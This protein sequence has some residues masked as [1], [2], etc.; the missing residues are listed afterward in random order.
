MNDVKNEMLKDLTLLWSSDLDDFFALI[1][2]NVLDNAGLD[3]FNIIISSDHEDEAK[4][5]AKYYARLLNSKEYRITSSKYVQTV[6]MD[7]LLEIDKFDDLHGVIFVEDFNEFENTN[8]SYA[9]VLMNLKQMSKDSINDLVFVLYNKV[10]TFELNS[11]LDEFGI[12]D[13]F[14]FNFN[15]LNHTKK[16]SE[17]LISYIF[18]QKNVKVDDSVLHELAETVLN[19]KSLNEAIQCIET[20]FTVLNDI[21][22]ELCSTD[23]ENFKK[24]QEKEEEL[25]E[26][27]K[28][29]RRNRKERNVLLLPLSTL[30]SVNVSKYESMV[31]G[32]KDQGYYVSQ[33]EPVPKMLAGM[34][35]AQGDQLDSI[36]VLNTSQTENECIKEELLKK[37]IPFTNTHKDVDEKGEKY[38]QCH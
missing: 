14:N 27:K 20:K 7:D 22:E 38:T 16:S 19:T 9:S 36:Y 3:A 26:A 37:L 33:L 23:E 31:E 17:R 15:L 6:L 11:R 8:E 29:A 24:I 13:T 32:V 1:D 5:F 4:R 34:L 25:G 35:N 18:E 30:N 28:K 12:S 2:K 21:S 10:K